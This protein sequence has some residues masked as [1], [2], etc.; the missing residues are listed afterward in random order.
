MSNDELKNF[1]QS[2]RD[3]LEATLDEVEHRVSPSYVSEQAF[4]WVSKSFDRHPVAWL[5]GIAVAVVGA[6]AAILW[7][8][9]DSDD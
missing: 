5:S 6:V 9:F 3:E 7:A 8:V 2:T 4:A 1:V